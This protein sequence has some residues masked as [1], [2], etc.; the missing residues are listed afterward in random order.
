MSS[1]PSSQ[2]DEATLV[3]L[4]TDIYN[5]LLKL[6][7]LK[8]D[9]VM[10]PPGEGHPLDFSR[11][12]ET[13]RIDSR[14]ISLIRHLPLHQGEGKCVVPAMRPVN[15]TM[16]EDLACS[17]D[18]DKRH[19]YAPPDESRLDMTNAKPTVLQL[20]Y[21]EEGPDPCL[22]LDLADSILLLPHP[23]HLYSVLII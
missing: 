6:G 19:F 16:A 2:Y 17:R 8:E 5:I 3:G 14:V 10:W 13:S 20:L 12:D 11:L 21:G 9:K 15:Y 18:I 4:V 23:N 1:Q 7:H 22:V